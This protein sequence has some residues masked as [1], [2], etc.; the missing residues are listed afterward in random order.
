LD[1]AVRLMAERGFERM[2]L[3]AVAEAAE[4]STATLHRR[5][6]SKEELA[7]AAMAVI[8]DETRPTPSG[9]LSLDLEAMVRQ[10]WHGLTQRVGMGLIGTVL[11]EERERPEL[12]NLFREGVVQPRVDA[13]VEMI[14][15][16][17]EAGQAPADADPTL[18]AELIAGAVLARYLSG[19]PA[20]ARWFRSISQAVLYSLG[21]PAA[22]VALKG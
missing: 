18:A 5:Y 22:G 17:Q 10:I 11:V 8:R 6:A 16:G 21:P 15:R 19:R 3:A 7:I 4:V 20:D 9:E 13:V 12:M 14:R 1:S 2:T